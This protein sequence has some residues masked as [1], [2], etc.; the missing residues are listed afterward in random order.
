MT[1][2][3]TVALGLSL[4]ITGAAPALAGGE[5]PH[6]APIATLFAGGYLAQDVGSERDPGFAISGAVPLRGG[7]HVMVAS[8]A[9]GGFDPARSVIVGVTRDGT[10]LLAGG[11]LDRDV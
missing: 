9:G 3:K 2:L 10:S 7:G 4:L 8:E 5:Q 6:T 1:N 11:G